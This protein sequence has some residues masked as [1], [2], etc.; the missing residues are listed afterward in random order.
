LVFTNLAYGN[1]LLKD[2][3]ASPIPAGLALIKSVA[4]DLWVV[5]FQAW[6]QVLQFPRP[7]IDGPITTLFYV[8]IVGI[9]GLAGFLFLA[10]TPD[11]E[12]AKRKRFWRWPIALGA[13][14]LL[15]AGGPYWLAKL[16]LNLGF[17]ANRFT[18]SFMLGASL[19]FAG[20]LELLPG[21]MRLAAVAI[22][23][24]LAAGRQA[25]W[26][27]SFRRDWKTQKA[28]FWQMTWRAPGLK[29]DTMVL[30]N[31]GPLNYYADNS[32]GAALN[33][34]YDPD[35]HT[36][37]MHYA[38]FFPLSRIAGTLP[39]LEPNHP[40]VFTFLVT[41]FYGNTSQAVAFYYQPP[42]CLRLLDPDID[43]VNRL[44]PAESM[45]REAA[46]LSSSKW[47]LPT[48]GARMPEVYGPEPAH[49]WCYYFERADLA[50]QSG[51]W[52]RVTELGDQA[53][54]LNDYPNDPIERFVFIEGYAHQGQWAR[55]HEL[56]IQSYK[57]SPNY[58]G[59]LL[60]KLIDRI[61]H[62]VDAG[63]TEESSLNDLRTKFSCLP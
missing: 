34:I 14:A 54:G 41:G 43:P 8:G 3:R 51:D 62:N 56:A 59:P 52:S 20:L 12:A 19:L 46:Q 21:R 18:I 61:D 31:E 6:S 23:I 1:V 37:P 33:W 53:F 5:T 17:P 50:A 25:L 35:N 15:V 9:V 11:L 39:S 55:A 45:M 13:A 10:R 26:A 38:L 47:I 29:P 27:D 22:L 32:L 30:M 48:N 60:C 4:V 57:V 24:G 49:G 58:V 28:M 16:D 42:A 63:N 2:L 40:V 44:I 7:V 36:A